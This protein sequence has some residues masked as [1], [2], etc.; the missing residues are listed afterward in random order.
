M[1]HDLE[2]ESKKGIK[3]LVNSECRIANHE[4]ISGSK[5]NIE[6]VYV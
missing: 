3:D 6:Y 2:S 1:P 4:N 5:E